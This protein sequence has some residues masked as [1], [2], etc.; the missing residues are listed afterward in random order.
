VESGSEQ[1]R[2]DEL[3]DDEIS[4]IAVASWMVRRRLFIVLPAVL[5]VLLTLP[6]VLTT[7]FEY[8][9]SASFLPNG[10]GGG[11][12]G[13]AAG[14]AAQFG[15]SMPRSGG[16]E[17]SPAFYQELLES[18]EILDGLVRDGL[19]VVT[20]TQ[21]KLDSLGEHQ[22]QVTSFI[23][24]SVIDDRCKDHVY[25]ISHLKASIGLRGWGQKDSL[26]EYKQEAYG[27]FVDL[28]ADMCGRLLRRTSS[29]HS[30][31]SLRSS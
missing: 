13:G 3:Y 23:M 10:G 30:L 22:E 1:V 11:G 7:T 12:I 17:R 28:K 8:T 29:G 21:G 25:E 2:G 14:L 4:L 31:G 26:V 24:L 6:A 9:A 5:G 16:S 18:R 19:R 20:S 15:T 27:M